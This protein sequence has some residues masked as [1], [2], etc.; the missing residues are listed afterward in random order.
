MLIVAQG[1]W[2]TLARH[3]HIV[4]CHSTLCGLGAAAF[5][6][7]S[8]PPLGQYQRSCAAHEASWRSHPPGPHAPYVFDLPCRT[9]RRKVKTNAD[10]KGFRRPLSR[11]KLRD[12]YSPSAA[13]YSPSPLV[14]ERGP[15]CHSHGQVCMTKR[16]ALAILS[17]LQGVFCGVFCKVV[18]RVFAR[19][20]ARWSA[21]FCRVSFCTIQSNGNKGQ[22][23][24]RR[25]SAAASVGRARWT[26]AALQLPD[27]SPCLLSR[28]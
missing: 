6:S 17:V 11:R 3:C 27:F 16:T 2:R 19:C 20:F 4:P 22:A 14:V 18:C 21:V 13:S 1:P 15:G 25:P 28:H 24:A 10:F 26:F 9:V 5:V 23:H 8:L 7:G 12:P